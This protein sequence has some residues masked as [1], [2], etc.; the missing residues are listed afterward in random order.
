MQ[1]ILKMYFIFAFI[2][3]SAFHN[4][5]KILGNVNY[6]DGSMLASKCFMITN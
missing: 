3:V 1:P 2:L 5:I 4:L 6:R